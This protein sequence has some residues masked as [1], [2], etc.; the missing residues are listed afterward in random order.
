ML[1][2]ASFLI[3]CLFQTASAQYMLPFAVR[4]DVSKYFGDTNSF[5]ATAELIEGK[6]QQG[7][8]SRPNLTFNFAYLNGMT[9]SEVDMSEW[10]DPKQRLGIPIDEIRK[11]MR[12]YNTERVITIIK[13][14]QA[15]SLTIYPKLKA[16]I[17]TSFGPEIAKELKTIPKPSSSR[18]LGKETIDQ[19]PCVKYEVTFPAE[20]GYERKEAWGLYAESAG[21][22]LL[23]R[24]TDLSELPVK[25]E[26]QT[27]AG[28]ETLV[29]KNLKAAKP[30][31]ALFE[32][33]PGY[34]EFSSLDALYKAKV[35]Q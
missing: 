1:L 14:N 18:E 24:A 22:A 34:K 31:A 4:L 7:E 3:C 33:P 25:F 6:I 10:Q 32:A 2:P 8:D 15:I 11:E 27:G 28:Y 30:A 23:W 12:K 13:P 16:Y 26:G 5:S 21:K 17:S 9:R 29:F 35:K 20:G 19:H